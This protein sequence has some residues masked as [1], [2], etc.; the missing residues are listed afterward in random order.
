MILD[1]PVYKT[2]RYAPEAAL[3]NAV[4][5]LFRRLAYVIEPPNPSIAIDIAGAG[6][7][8]ELP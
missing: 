6:A 2:S 3:A 4:R 1:H 8:K 5:T 7:P